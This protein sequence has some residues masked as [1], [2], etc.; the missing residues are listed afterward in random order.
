LQTMLDVVGFVGMSQPAG[1]PNSI[2]KYRYNSADRSVSP[3]GSLCDP[4]GKWVNKLE[5]IA[6]SN[7]AAVKCERRPAGDTNA[8]T[9]RLSR[10]M[11]TKDGRTIFSMHLSKLKG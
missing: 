10:E 6:S 11:K 8:L 3:I 7:L 5:D 4:G 2:S 1:Q 9:A